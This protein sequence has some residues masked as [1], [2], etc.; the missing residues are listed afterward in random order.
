VQRIPG[1]TLCGNVRRLV[2]RLLGMNETLIA[3]LYSFRLLLITEL[4]Q[5][6]TKPQPNQ[7]AYENERV[8]SRN[9]FLPGKFP[10]VLLITT[11]LVLH[12]NTM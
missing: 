11:S 4:V 12:H 6:K 7:V 8:V 9:I 3:S 1:Q 2:K 10:T 5:L